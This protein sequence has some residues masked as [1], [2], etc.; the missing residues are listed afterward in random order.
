MSAIIKYLDRHAE[1]ECQRLGGFPGNFEQGLIVPIYNEDIQVVNYFR[2]FAKNYAGTL[3]ILVVN[4][5]DSD[6]TSQW[7]TDIF[8]ALSSGE[9]R[10]RTPDSANG[11]ARSP[12]WHSASKQLMLYPLSDSSSLLLVDRCRPGRAILD[13]QGVGLARKIGND[14][15]CTL[16]H[17][18]KV[19]SHWMSNTDADVQL[20][21]D[22]F[23][24][25]NSVPNNVA[26]VI[27]PFQHIFVDQTPQ[28]PTLLYE[29]SL[30]YYVAGL[31][32]AGSGN[33]YHTIGSLISV[34]FKHYCQVRG[35][36]K[37][38]AAED[39]Y[40][41][42]KLIKTGEIRS[43]Q[44]SK[45]NIAA[46]ESSRVPFGTGP[47]VIKINGLSDPS[48]MRIYHPDGF[49]YLHYFLKLLT[50][51]ADHKNTIEASCGDLTIESQHIVSRELLLK[52]AVAVQLDKAVHHCYRQG[53]TSV[54]RLKHLIGWFDGFKTLKLI[55]FIRDNGLGM[56]TFR[57][58]QERYRIEKPFL[59]TD[60]LQGISEKI[61]LR[62]T[63]EHS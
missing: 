14:I 21:T 6:S 29:F 7:Y 18:E 33:A 17:Q 38:S 49:V 16:I 52:F 25:T 13:E 26:A 31:S 9:H 32:W 46:R 23:A 19:A 43:L 5:P 39:F 28:L 27:Y 47:A 63:N 37:R 48:E 42:N 45:I 59:M 54:K 3:L 15:L 40:L 62:L 11:L 2:E 34:H 55:H 8:T 51:L 53:D 10:N 22:Y 20:P 35:F 50:A 24:A 44:R 57:Q 4:R 61:D 30:H 60:D 41:L 1:P 36:P 56:I 12:Q 58:W